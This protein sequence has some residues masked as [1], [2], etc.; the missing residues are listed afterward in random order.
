[1]RP[2]LS[3]IV[4]L[5][6]AVAIGACAPTAPR[7]AP[8]F[9]P[10]GEQG[11]PA[12]GQPGR[13]LRVILRA[14]PG[15][16]AGTILIPT[17]ISTGSQRRTF[18]AGLTLEDSD[19][20]FRPYLAEVS[21]QLNTD[22]WRVFPDGRMETTYRLRPNLT[23]HDGSALG[24][25]D[26]VFAWR[27]YSSPEFG[28][29]RSLPYTLMEEVAA[30]DPRTVVIRWRQPYPDAAEL[31]EEQLAPLPRN[32]LD[33]IYQRERDNLPNHP[34]WTTDYVGAGPYRVDRWEP[35]AFVEATAFD[36][37]TLGRPRID[38]VKFT[39]S[40]DFNATL[41]NLLAGEADM[42]LDDSI[43][44]DQ[45]L[46]LERDWSARSAGTVL[47]RPHLPRFVQVQHRAEYA[48]PQAVRDVRVR[49]ALTYAIDRQPINEALFEGKGITTDSLI[50][51]TLE[52]Y[53]AVDRAVA[54]YPY[55]L[56]RSEQLMNE[57]GFTRDSA[58][59]HS[60]AD[61]RRLNLE[62]RNIQ[63]AQNDAERSIIADGWRKAGFEIEEDVFTPV[64]TRDGQ[65]LGTFRALS[66]TSS[67]AVREGLQIRD[68][69][70]AAISRPETRWIGANRGGWSSAEYDRIIA[71]W[72]TT[73]DPNE[74]NQLLAQAIK[75]LTE[76]LGVL[77]L[78]FNPGVIAYAAG[79]QG[80]KLKA[81]A[82]DVS[83][84]IHEWQWR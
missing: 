81:P 56:R 57:A 18:N 3:P 69:T 73:L 32:I 23:W 79:L 70:S 47:Y 63:S 40:A 48:N 52:Y 28:I 62:V 75:A 25:E 10:E 7:G 60:G 16:L 4:L 67:A 11:Q 49:R 19:G 45:G 13:T 22:S 8:P 55:D 12:T 5:L 44:V 80:I 33:P 53:S 27:L 14:E 50:Y 36:G 58:G 17:G 42:P 21:P 26:F 51:P 24:A 35:G 30:P 71:G 59:F 77:P 6:C 15:S 39:W 29:S 46:I 37:H 68:Y 9:A 43:R 82:T 2:A 61:G 66:I 20:R 78:H 38:R 84:N 64:Q 34:F 76:D 74:R 41:A 83:W 1:M 31:D 54:K 65:L 72:L